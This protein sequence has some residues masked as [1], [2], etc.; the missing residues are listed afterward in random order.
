MIKL[1][2]AN[3]LNP[4]FYRQY[5]TF[6][7]LYNYS[8]NEILEDLRTLTDAN[9]FES[10]KRADTSFLAACLLSLVLI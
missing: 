10:L 5:C 7:V 4:E 2:E 9:Y 6:F 8:R 3:G 1:P